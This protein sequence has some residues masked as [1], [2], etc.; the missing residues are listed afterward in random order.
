[1]SKPPKIDRK[2]LN[3]PD[4]FVTQGRHVLEL[5]VE[6]QTKILY[7][8]LTVGVIFLGWYFYDWRK[9]SL[10]E[11]GWTEY[12]QVVKAPEGERWEKM[13]K[14]A[15]DFN[16]SPV[17]QFAAVQLADHY[18]DEAKKESEKNSKEPSSSAGAAVEWYSNALKNPKL[19]ENEKGVLLI[20][21]AGAYEMAQKWDEALNNY[22]DAVRIGFEGKP[23][24]LLG[25][26]RVYE[27]KKENPRAVEIYEKVSADFLNTEYGRLAKGYL[28]R[29]KSSLFVEPKA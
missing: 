19:T 22:S 23:L 25:Q 6:H 11:Q 28:R 29:L 17:G 26:A 14:L 16:S 7:G 24:A 15:S 21:R 4:E 9:S 3:R 20:N 5:F 10:N 12:F 2:E 1:M 27:I 13:K 8:L 18:F